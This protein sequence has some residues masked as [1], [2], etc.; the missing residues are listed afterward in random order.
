[1]KVNLL[2]NKISSIKL[3]KKNKFINVIDIHSMFYGCKSLRLIHDISKWN[4]DE[5][6]TL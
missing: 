5:V 3:A 6:A 1:M 4:T 2:L